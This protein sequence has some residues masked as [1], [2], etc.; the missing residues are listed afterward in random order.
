MY[1]Y[2]Y[3]CFGREVAFAVGG[4]AA[5][6]AVVVVVVVA[7]GADAGP[8]ASELSGSVMVGVARATRFR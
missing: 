6:A 2:L 7:P 4:S 8:G 3:S 5:T 1:I